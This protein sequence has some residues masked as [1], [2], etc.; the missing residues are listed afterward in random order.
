MF[1]VAL[2]R[3]LA[4]RGVHYGCWCGRPPAASMCQ[5][6][7]G[8]VISDKGDRPWTRLAELEWIPSKAHFS[9][10]TGLTRLKLP[11]LAEKLRRKDDGGVLREARSDGGRNRSLLVY[12]HHH[13][14]RL[15]P[16]VGA[17]GEVDRASTGQAIC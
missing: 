14:A 6:E 10:F 2:A 11:V 9:T 15:L 12:E 1:A 8:L 3:N 7:V 4:S 13:Y 16:G 5:N 17:F